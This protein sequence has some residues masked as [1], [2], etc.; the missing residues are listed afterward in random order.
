M[1]GINALAF[2]QA[3]IFEDDLGLPATTAR[4]IAASVFTW[5]T[6]CSPIGVLTVDRFGRRKLMLVAALGMGISM[7]VIA[8]GSSQPNNSSAIA[9][10]AAFIFMFSLFFPTGFLGLTFLYAAEIAPLS[11]RSSITAIST[12]SAWLFNF[13]RDFFEFCEAYQYANCSN[14]P[15]QVVAEITPPKDFREAELPGP[16]TERE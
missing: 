8:G 10:A 5:Q 16:Q 12:S 11:H 2:Y 15:L 3:T 7:A 4:I 1:S 14:P 6:L 13:V 9:A